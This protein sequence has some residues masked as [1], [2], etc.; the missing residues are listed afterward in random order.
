VK[1]IPGHAFLQPRGGGREGEPVRPPRDRREG[2]RGRS[3]GPEW[4]QHSSGGEK[5]KG[6]IS[7]GSGRERGP[8]VRK[9]DAPGDVLDRGRSSGR[10]KP[11]NPQKLVA[12]KAS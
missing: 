12:K 2:K 4:G 9:A 11:T 7:G 1:P 8:L 10:E 3:S 5:G 6:Q